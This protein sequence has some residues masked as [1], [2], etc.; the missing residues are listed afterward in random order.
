MEKMVCYGK[1]ER[2]TSYN[3]YQSKLMKNAE[4]FGSDIHIHVLFYSGIISYLKFRSFYDMSNLFNK[5]VI[6]LQKR[7]FF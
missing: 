2:H 6:L 4:R 7:G 1:S 5:K 3:I